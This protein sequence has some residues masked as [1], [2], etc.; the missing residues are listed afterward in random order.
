MR[1]LFHDDLRIQKLIDEKKGNFKSPY[2]VKDF[3]IVKSEL[4]TVI[5]L[6]GSLLERID[7]SF[8]YEVFFITEIKNPPK[9]PKK[10][11]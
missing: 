3:F 1:T 6:K 8:I 11:F 4:R 9:S 5:F 10:G 2:T 7:N